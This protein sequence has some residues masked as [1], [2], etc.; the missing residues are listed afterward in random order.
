[1]ESTPLLI[2]LLGPL[3]PE[4]VVLVRVRS[5]CQMDLLKIIIIR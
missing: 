5:M 1:M 2:L 3:W 4:D